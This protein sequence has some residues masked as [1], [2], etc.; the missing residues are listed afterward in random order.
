MT[1]KAALWL[2]VSLC[3][4]KLLLASAPAF[5]FSPLNNHSDLP[6]VLFTASVQ[7]LRYNTLQGLVQVQA[8]TWGT[9]IQLWPLLILSAENSQPWEFSLVAQG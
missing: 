3:W 1:S 8:E 9:R 6:T 7:R 5:N 2:L 4:L